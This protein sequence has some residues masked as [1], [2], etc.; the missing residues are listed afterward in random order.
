MCLFDHVRS[1]NTNSMAFMV[2]LGLSAAISTRVSNVLATRV[3]VL[4]AV[5]VSEG[6]VAL[7]VLGLR[8]QR[9]GGGGQV[10]REDG[11]MP[12]LAVS[13]VL[14]CQQGVLS[15]TVRTV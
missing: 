4:L 14:D 1:L 3:V 8:V 11:M 13:I 7:L 12:L 6:L 9:R 2:L 5:G 10:H 15:G